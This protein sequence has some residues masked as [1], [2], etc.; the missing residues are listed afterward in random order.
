MFNTNQLVREITA[1]PP[2]A[3]SH[4]LRIIPAAEGGG[5]GGEGKRERKKMSKGGRKKGQVPER[6][7]H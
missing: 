2:T 1:N 7:E 5:G 6:D 4:D 3:K